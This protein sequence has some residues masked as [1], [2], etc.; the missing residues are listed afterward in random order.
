[1][2]VVALP[3]A[4]LLIGFNL[5]QVHE[6]LDPSEYIGDKS[7]DEIDLANELRKLPLHSGWHHCLH[8]FLTL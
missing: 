4:K 8:C 6:M 1:M 3:L 7:P 2:L 5:H